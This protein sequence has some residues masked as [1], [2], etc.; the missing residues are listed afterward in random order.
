LALVVLLL[1]CQKDHPS[2]VDGNVGPG[3]VVGR[4]T[5]FATE[6]E[7]VD[8]A[9]VL[10]DPATAEP[11]SDPAPT[12]DQGFFR[13]VDVAPGSYVLYLQCTHE[14]IYQRMLPT[15]AVKAARESRCDIRTRPRS[16]A[17]FQFAGTIRD[18]ESGRPISR[19]C[20]GNATWGLGGRDLEAMF[21]PPDHNFLPAFSDTNGEFI[22]EAPVTEPWPDWQY[23][24][25]M[26]SLTVT[27]RGYEPYTLAGPRG[28]YFPIGTEP[29]DAL[30]RFEINLKPATYGH[31]D[32]PGTGVIRGRTVLVHAP[33]GG[34]PVA[35]SLVRALQSDTLVE[36][37]VAIP[38]PGVTGV[39]LSSGAFL[40]AGVPP[41]VYSVVSGFRP[42]DHFVPLGSAPDGFWYRAPV[43]VA[44][45][46]TVDAGDIPVG[47][48]VELL[49]PNDGS[50]ASSARPTFA[51]SKCPDGLG[52]TVG[53][54]EIWVSTNG[55]EDRIW[56]ASDTQLTVPVPYP[57][58][59]ELRWKVE[60]HAHIDGQ[61]ENSVTTIGR[62]EKIFR[63]RIPQ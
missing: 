13:I 26:P 37:N 11:C 4:V 43:A 27:R 30:L 12:D 38:L 29:P 2:E 46:D 50:Q 32:D 22:C 42:D 57:A 15:V 18:L 39:S 60:V 7:I 8:A 41:G 59:A 3:T 51:W 34:V 24:A 10:I 36:K 23:Q 40:L 14:T 54:Y 21:S 61:P 52:Y 56:A 55:Y 5:E 44:A 16:P 35:L 33:I 62:S 28:G 25:A 58:G 20:I 17:R 31:P 45:G 53:H 47:L 6:A 19:A 63:L 48:V 1:S 9:V 49:A